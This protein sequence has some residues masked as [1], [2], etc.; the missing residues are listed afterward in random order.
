M[1]FYR[2]SDTH[3][4]D[5][6]R[7][8]H[9]ERDC[10][11]REVDDGTVASTTIES[12]IQTLAHPRANPRADCRT[13]LRFASFDMMDKKP[14]AGSTFA[15]EKIAQAKLDIFNKNSEQAVAPLL[16]IP[17]LEHVL[18]DEFKQCK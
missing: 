5:M 11:H 14:V 12:A 16:L 4:R 13:Y 7:H 10:R 17:W 8:R 15:R 9:T 1:Y 6:Q 2:M 3:I 18:S